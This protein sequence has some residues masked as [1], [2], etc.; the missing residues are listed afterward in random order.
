MNSAA[1]SLHLLTLVN[2]LF[3]SVCAFVP[4][5]YSGA[6]R[7]GRMAAVALTVFGMSG[8]LTRMGVAGHLPLFGTFE[9][10]YT[11]SVALALLGAWHVLRRPD[12]MRDTWRLMAPWSAVLLVYGSFFRAEPIPLTISEQSLWV[13]VHVLFAWFAFAGFIHATSLSAVR[14][15]GLRISGIGMARIDTLLLQRLGVGFFALSVMMAVGSWYLFILF[16]T[17]WRWEIVGTLT[18]VAWIAYSLILHAILFRGWS[19][20]KLDVAVVCAAPVTIAAFWIWSAL[21][22]TYHFFD[23]PFLRPY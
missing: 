17:F 20:S 15:T 21:P 13:D 2:A 4:S 23:I 11:A 16:G 19:G 14:L 18:L 12:D 6:V 1:N 7:V 10:T 8:L 22:M 3:L 5:R 9:N